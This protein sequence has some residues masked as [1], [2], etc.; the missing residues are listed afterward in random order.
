[1]D[2]DRGQSWWQVVG[3]AREWVM[4]LELAGLREPRLEAR[5][6][7]QQQPVLAQVPEQVPEQVQKLVLGLEAGLE[8]A[9]E[10]E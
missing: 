3:L 2:F 4:E 7:L 9:P 1:M 10:P 8:P 6:A 5:R